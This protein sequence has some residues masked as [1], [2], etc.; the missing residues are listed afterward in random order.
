MWV[1]SAECVSRMRAVMS[2]HSEIHRHHIG[3]VFAGRQLE[4]DRTLSHYHI[5]GG[6]TLRLMLRLR[7]G[8]EAAPKPARLGDLDEELS[9]LHIPEATSLLSIS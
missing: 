2:M 8:M 3:F 6:N 9:L 1:R 4:D 7:G 5:E